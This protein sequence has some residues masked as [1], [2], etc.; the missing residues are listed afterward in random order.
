MSDPDTSC[1]ARRG[2]ASVAGVL[3]GATGGALLAALVS[4]SGKDKKTDVVAGALGG[5]L[6]GALISHV[7]FG[8]GNMGGC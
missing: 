2:R 5:M 3:I 4:S 8:A 6:F 7:A 1:T